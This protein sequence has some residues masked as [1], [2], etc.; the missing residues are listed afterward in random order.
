MILNYFDDGKYLK[1]SQSIN[2][3]DEAIYF[4]VPQGSILR[5]TL[6]KLN[7]NDI[8]QQNYQQMPL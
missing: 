3:P 1:V 2:Y 5:P 6:F 4:G 7:M 8:L